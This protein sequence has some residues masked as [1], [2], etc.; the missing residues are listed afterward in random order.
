M[1]TPKNIKKQL[2]IKEEQLSNEVNNKVNTD[3]L[4]FQ[5]QIKP[6]PTERDYDRGYFFRYF[7]IT[8][9]TNKINETTEQSFTLYKNN[10]RTPGYEFYN[11]ISVKWFIS[12]QAPVTIAFNN[13]KNIEKLANINIKAYINN[14]YLEYLK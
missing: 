10:P 6:S 8:L 13:K 2:E 12:K 1:F 9:M 11:I 5:I 3:P 14:K 7:T 4:N